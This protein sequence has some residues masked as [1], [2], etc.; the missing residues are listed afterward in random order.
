MVLNHV[1]HTLQ[2]LMIVVIVLA[3]M[4]TV[5]MASHLSGVPVMRDMKVQ[6]VNKVRVLDKILV[7][8]T[9]VPG[10]KCD[11]YLC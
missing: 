9:H 6:T 5:R 2:T 11:V 7:Y 8:H 1:L 3:F 10:S 4:A